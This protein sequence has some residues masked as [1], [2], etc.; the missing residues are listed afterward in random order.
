MPNE[1]NIISNYNHWKNLLK[2][3][4]VIY[5]DLEFLLQKMHL[6]QNNSKKSYTERKAKYIPSCYAWC[7]IISFDA[8]KNEYS[9]YREQ[10]CMKKLCEKV[11]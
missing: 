10:N 8:S 6:C 9:Y 4:F 7:R 2:A 1:D 11:I 5:V 3:S